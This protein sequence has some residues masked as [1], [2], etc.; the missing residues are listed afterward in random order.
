MEERRKSGGRLTGE[1]VERL[2]DSYKGESSDDEV[3][4]EIPKRSARRSNESTRRQGEVVEQ[5]RQRQVSG[6][7]RGRVALPTSAGS[8]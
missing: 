5:E 2:I 8:G 4:I 3:E 7:E 1:E 6:E